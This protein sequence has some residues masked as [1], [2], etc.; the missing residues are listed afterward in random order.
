MAFPMRESQ[1]DMAISRVLPLDAPW[2]EG[3]GLPLF[4]NV[5][6]GLLRLLEDVPMRAKES[7]KENGKTMWRSLYFGFTPVRPRARFR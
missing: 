1:W 2:A 3:Y 6:L 7:G 5:L 4:W